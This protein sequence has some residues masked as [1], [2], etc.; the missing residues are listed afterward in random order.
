MPLPIAQIASPASSVHAPRG[1][2][3]TRPRTPLTAPPSPS[4]LAASADDR[5]AVVAVEPLAHDRRAV[6]GGERLAHDRRA[7]VGVDPLAHDR[8]AVVG[9]ELE[10][11]RL[12]GHLIA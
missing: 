7:V 3:G 10:L 2:S 11:T 12:R 6:V 5:R 9:G 1:S 8:R 4:P